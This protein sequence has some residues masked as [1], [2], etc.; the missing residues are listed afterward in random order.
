MGKKRS[1]VFHQLVNNWLQP[2][3]N[4]PFWIRVPFFKFVTLTAM[5]V[6]YSLFSSAKN[7]NLQIQYLVFA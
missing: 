6:F 3:T 1:E 7:F 5:Q 2:Y 4:Q